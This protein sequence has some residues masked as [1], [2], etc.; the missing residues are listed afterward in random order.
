MSANNR[1]I[2]VGSDRIDKVM[3]CFG[4]VSKIGP[5]ANCMRRQTA[6]NVY[7]QRIILSAFAVLL[8]PLQNQD[9][10]AA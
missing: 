3:G 9:L 8:T 7:M 4:P 1:R 10:L 2:I 6:D 5:M